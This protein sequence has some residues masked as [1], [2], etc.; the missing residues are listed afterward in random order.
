MPR[1]LSSRAKWLDESESAISPVRGD[2]VSTAN[3][4]VVVTRVPT[5]RRAREDQRVR[6]RERIDAC[7]S[8]LVQQGGAEADAAQ[9][10]RSRDSSTSRYALWPL[11]RSTWST[12][13]KSPCTASLPHPPRG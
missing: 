4:A 11:V 9:Y 5:R 7:G 3:F 12:R 8:V 1:R 13:P 6:R 2:L 10:F